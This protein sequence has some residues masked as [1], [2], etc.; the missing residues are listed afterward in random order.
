MLT[1]ERP[2]ARADGEWNVAGNTG[3]VLV[4]IPGGSFSMGAQ[5]DPT[6][7]RF[8]SQ[9]E[10]REKLRTAHLDP[11]FISKYEMTQGQWLELTDAQPSSAVPGKQFRSTPRT[12][13][14][15]PVEYIDWVTCDGVIRHVNLVL[16]TEM[17]W[18]R[19]A[20]AGTDLRYLTSDDFE[21][22]HAKFN[23]GD[24][25]YFGQDP[26]AAGALE[27]GFA[28][29]VRVDTF[30]PNAYGLYNV[31][32]NVS[33]WCRE[34]HADKDDK[35]K[36]GEHDG[37]IDVSSSIGRKTYRGGSFRD[38]PGSLRV[39][40]RF[41]EVTTLPLDTVGVRPARALDP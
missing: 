33:E 28:R 10:S 20:R 41:N 7:A 40:A 21:T 2:I 8:D 30:G 3:L 11:F 16:P 17:Q 1:G 4:L 27:D 39:S 19:A 36:L 14:S 22:V 37:E 13:R 15:N 35:V 32:G 24:R 9:A 25:S 31:L 5:P 26:K 23:F 29:H 34:W 38:P 12:S 6:K 18:E